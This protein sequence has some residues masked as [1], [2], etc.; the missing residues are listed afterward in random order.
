MRNTLLLLAAVLIGCFRSSPAGAAGPDFAREVRPILA[1]HCFKCH[2]PD[3]KA[4]KARLRL[5]TRDDA[6]KGGRS[7]QSAFVPGKPAESELV[8]RILSNDENEL[9]PPPAARK[10][11]TAEQKDSLKRW[12]AAGGEY[13]P[14][15]AFVKPT[16]PKIPTLSRDAERSA[17][18]PIDNFVFAKIESLGIEKPQPDADKY[19]LVRRVYLDL[20]G[21]PPTPAEADA[22]VAD[23]SPDAYEK[24]VDKLLASPHYGE[25]WARRWL[26]LARYAD[27]NGYEKDRPRSIWPY[28]D[29]VIK[30]L[31]DDLSFDRFTIEQLAGDLMPNATQ[32]QRVATGFHRNTML[33]EEGGIDPLE[34][35]YY[36]VVD[37][38]NTTGTVWLGL[39]L[40]CC[41]CHNHKFDPI[42]QRDYYRVMAF[43]NN[44]EEPEIEVP[45]DE[46]SKKR[47]E[48]TAK[49]RDLY[50][51][52]PG[53]VAPEKFSAWLAAGREQAVR[54][55]ILMPTK[56]EAGLTRLT[57]LADGSLLA[58]GDATKHDIYELTFANLPAGVT[59]WRLEALPHQSLPA[60]GPGRAYYEGPGGDFLLGDLKL[61]LDG[62]PVKFAG[63]MDT[64]GQ[65]EFTA[66]LALDANE[67][68]GW[69]GARRPGT[70]S[71]A[72]FTPAA[73]LPAARSAMLK[74]TFERHYAASLGRLRVA[75]T[76]DA[77][78][79][80][81]S[82]VPAEIEA[83][84]LIPESQL[85]A[86]QRAALVGHYAN[87]APELE[88]ARD[89]IAALQKQFPPA[90][91]T[92]VIKERPAD[93]PRKTFVH[94]RGEFL[95]PAEEV[96]P[97][98]LTALHP[99]PT[100]EP[101]NR[102]TFARWLVSSDNPLAARV[103]VNRAWAAFFGRG[104]VATLNDF[105]YQGDPPTH[106]ELLDWLAVEFMDRGWSMKRLHKLIVLSATYRQT[107]HETPDL[108]KKDPENRLLTRGPRFRLEAEEI[109]DSA[110]KAGGLLS[111]KIGGPSVFPPQPPG[112]T[113]TAYAGG[114]W[115][116]SAGED[117]YRRG[118][119]TY[120]KRTTPYAMAATFDAP[121]GE[122]CTA[123]REVSNTP[124][125]ALTMLNDPAIT[126][127]AQALGQVATKAD[128]TT[129]AKVTMVFRR[130]LIRPPTA[131]ETEVLEKFY[132]AQRGK[133]A[134][135]AK[136]A[137]KFA[138]SDNGDV[139][140]RAAW[141]AVARAVMNLDEF[142]TRE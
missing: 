28:R 29:W 113:D 110:L 35:R 49:I 142:V 7:G 4:R 127:A 2:G 89:E 114:A 102:L 40:G 14:H 24:L 26:D 34:F 141:T 51:A 12:V 138:G 39:T 45:S 63:A 59:A 86:E 116:V 16:R 104:I 46:V 58:S 76:T 1:N 50:T 23:T 109:R 32:S 123:R 27:T 62:T 101:L 22:F 92:L 66:A 119:Y 97:G 30:A 47:A 133:F 64:G 137:A 25:R 112:V 54:W 125:Q 134:A 8:R 9:M 60:G 122:A 6:L 80:K 48:L 19:T 94:T 139:V 68:T 130:C 105:G 140:E 69:A 135:D 87:T 56:I 117:R 81:A 106:P 98:G 128:G 88:A 55:T 83:L 79:V 132:A 82:D 121:S 20:I 95:Q 11:L 3:D 18:N 77:R 72:V 74:L 124:L 67:Q 115:K 17:R 111:E 120:S 31:N 73:P 42:P 5:D 99:L 33:N 65:K 52:L 100:G 103:V 136:A 43:L 15:W 78:P 57:P 118:L 108:G 85:T 107:S 90:P 36:A 126:E 96:Q 53:K 91:T 93:F 21:L 131:D 75:V 10:Q 41:Q 70:P 38:V 71:T 84:Q 13:R 61:T 129:G 37:R 44:A